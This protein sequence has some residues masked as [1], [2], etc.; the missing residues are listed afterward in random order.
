MTLRDWLH[1]VEA[2][3]GVL[4][5]RLATGGV[6]LS[7]GIQKF[8]FPAELGAGRFAK[9]GIPS[10]QFM[11]PFVGWVEIICGSLLLLGLLTR[12]AA[13]PLVIDIVIAIMT[14]K[15]PMWLERGFWITAHEARTDVA[16]LLGAL[17]LLAVGPG[18]LSLDA[19]LP[20]TRPARVA[21]ELPRS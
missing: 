10:P 18:P 6:F 20:A 8:L 21:P 4:L 17:F 5:I 15:F 13:L 1:P 7:E 12:L 11:A 3:P 14:T 16:M 9:I 2:P 19:A